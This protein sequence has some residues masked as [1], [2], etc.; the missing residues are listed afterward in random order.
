M[1]RHAADPSAFPR[2]VALRMVLVLLMLGA[3]APPQG[4]ALLL[5]SGDGT[6][7]TSAPPGVPGWDNVGKR[8]GGPT[9]VYVGNR[10]VLTAGHVGAGIVV[11]D[12]ERYDPVPGTLH[13][14]TNPDGVAADLLLFR[15]ASAP[16]LPPL[17]LADQTPRIGQKTVMVGTGASRGQSIT[18]D[19][20]ELGLVD[21]FLWKPDNTKRWGTNLVSSRRT[22]VGH[23]ASGDYT[24]AIPLSF[25]RI[26]DPLGT[27]HEAT[28]G[29][30][31]SGGALFALADALRPE[32]GWV[33]AGILFSVGT[34]PHQPPRSSLYGALT[35]AADIATY[36][37]QIMDIVYPGCES[38]DEEGVLDCDA[39]GHVTDDRDETE[40][41]RVSVGLLALLGTI[42]CWRVFALW[43]AR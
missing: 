41:T 18:I 11:F 20:P 8:L 43:R 36:R 6:G 4:L 35:Y 31:D 3:V 39:R 28:A 42:G 10:W 26:D 23:S 38:T 21:G 33:L 30:G 16:D 24:R 5:D 19:S 13:K 40:L 14:L 25:D 17:R 22:T 15:L 1:S 7:N 32:E 9:V 37:D 29:K 12:G 2:R 27:H 34:T